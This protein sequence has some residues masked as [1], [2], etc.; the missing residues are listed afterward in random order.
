[1]LVERE[2]FHRVGGFS[3]GLR[4]GVGLDCYAR[5]TEQGLRM[6]MLPMVVLERRLHADNNGLREAASRLQYA[7]VLKA[8]LDRRRSRPA[9]ADVLV[10]RV[11][12]SGAA[13]SRERPLVGA[14]L[15]EECEALAAW[16]NH[17]PD[18]PTAGLRWIADG[19]MMAPPAVVT[20]S[21]MKPSNMAQA[22]AGGSGFSYVT[23]ARRRSSGMR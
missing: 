1:M 6:L 3:T 14:V 8:A 18:D 2:A 16:N 17:F 7:R 9:I 4:V 23:D 15:G 11:L 13:A 10:A 12:T 19:A 22:G 5:A 20:V 21:R